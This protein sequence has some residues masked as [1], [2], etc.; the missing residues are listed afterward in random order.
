MVG[1]IG[2]TVGLISDLSLL[3]FMMAG[4]LVVDPIVALGTLVTFSAIGGFIYLLLHKRAEQIGF[5]STHLVVAS[6]E[7]IIEALNLY[8]ELGVRHRRSDYSR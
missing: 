6:N 3:L 8:R 4:L 5:R 7:S 1:V 2:N